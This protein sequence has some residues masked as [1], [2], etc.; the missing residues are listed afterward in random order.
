[1]RDEN[2]DQNF[3]VAAVITGGPTLYSCRQCRA[4]VEE[5]CTYEHLWW[6]EKI[7]RAVDE[8]DGTID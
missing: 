6:H 2:I 3:E 7:R 5:R 8:H 4:L 1:M